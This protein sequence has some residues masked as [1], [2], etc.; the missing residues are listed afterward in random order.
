MSDI[1]HERDQDASSES[2]LTRPYAVLGWSIRK[3]REDFLNLS[4]DA[5]AKQMGVGL[6]TLQNYESGVREASLSFLMKLSDDSGVPLTKIIYGDDSTLGRPV[7][8]DDFIFIPR[9]S[10]QSTKNPDATL[11]DAPQMGMF[12][13]PRQWLSAKVP[14]VDPSK[15]AVGTVI[16][17]VM[18]PTILTGDV[19]LIDQGD[20][21]IK[22]GIFVINFNGSHQVNR[23]QSRGKNAVYLLSD[24]NAYPSFILRDERLDAFKVLGRVRWFG[25]TI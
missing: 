1:D 4:R 3:V 16:G 18:Q 13:F 21:D 10:L 19:V 14:G 23:L 7:G 11:E 22:D 25:R 2:E 9:Y 5:L 8:A 20:T 17:D 12:S 6:S 15:L 24:N